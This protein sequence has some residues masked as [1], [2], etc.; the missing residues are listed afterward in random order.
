MSDMYTG[1]SAWTSCNTPCCGPVGKCSRKANF[2]PNLTEILKRGSGLQTIELEDTGCFGCARTSVS[3][4]SIYSTPTISDYSFI[5][6]SGTTLQVDTDVPSIDVDCRIYFSQT[7]ADS[8][9]ALTTETYTDRLN[10]DII[11]CGSS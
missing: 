1:R 2:Y 5:T 9:G 10:V 11:S 3:I 4:S 6:L 7:F 8:S